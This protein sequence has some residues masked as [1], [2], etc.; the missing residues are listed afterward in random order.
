MARYVR[1][2][3]LQNAGELH[4]LFQEVILLARDAA[5]L[6]PAERGTAALVE[7]AYRDW[8]RE[9]DALAALTAVQATE[10]IKAELAATARRP[11]TGVRPHLRD[12]IRCRPYAIVGPRGVRGG[13][14]T[15]SVG[16]A[17]LQALERV[18]NPFDPKGVPYWIVQEKGTARNVGRTLRGYFYDRGHTNPTRPAPGYTGTKGAQPLFLP[19]RLGNMPRSVA[20][21]IGPKG[22]KGGKG[23]IQNPIPARHFIGDAVHPG[24]ADVAKVRWLGYHRVA[25][26]KAIAELTP[27][28]TALRAGARRRRP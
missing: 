23:V 22:G 8:M 19:G 15:G 27:A 17:D 25:E 2:F 7:R 28:I 4:V 12:A 14:P 13:V 1:A 18:K 5:R 20:G 9:L 3:I 6:N 24:G 16:I 11:D 26:D 10:A 21:G